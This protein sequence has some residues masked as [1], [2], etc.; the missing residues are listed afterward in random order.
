[1]SRSL[2]I[3]LCQIN[4]VPGGI[5]ENSRRLAEVAAAAAEAGADLCVMPELALLG[6]SPRDLLFRRS[7]IAAAEQALADLAAAVDQMAGCLTCFRVSND[8]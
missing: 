1:M 5:P 8:D 7:F 6:Y 3:A 2:R 4:T